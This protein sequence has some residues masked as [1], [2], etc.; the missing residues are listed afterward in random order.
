MRRSFLWEAKLG[1]SP[2]VEKSNRSYKLA[3][4][5]KESL[6]IETLIGPQDR[7]FQ[8]PFELIYIDI[9]LQ[10]ESNGV[11]RNAPLKMN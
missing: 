10:L 4:L 6:I 2:Q 3:L 1:P 9:S 8:L 7:Q 11:A 5:V